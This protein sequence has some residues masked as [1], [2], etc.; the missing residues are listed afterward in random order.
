MRYLMTFSYDG[1]NFNG[2]QKQPD[3]RTV[4]EEIEKCLTMLNSNKFVSISATGRTDAKVHALNQMAHFDLDNNIENLEFRLNKMLPDDIYVKK[5]VLVSDDF[6]A[7]FNVKSKEYIYY[8]NVGEYNPFKR[9]YQYQYNKDLDV[10]KM[11]EA[12]KLLIGEHDFKSFTKANSEI[13]DYVRTIFK[14]SVSKNEDI[15]KISI[16]GSGFLRY[17]VRNIVGL[18]IEIG[19]GKKNIKDVSTILEAKDRTESSPTAP[20]CGLYLNKINY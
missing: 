8:I 5:V 20:A 11:E 2:Y 19:E 14:T 15:I 17:M 18:L 12:L 6:H 1:T 4:Q 9:N 7:R 3:S 16:E 13:D 10:D